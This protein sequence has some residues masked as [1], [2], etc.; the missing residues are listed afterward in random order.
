[1]AFTKPVMRADDAVVITTRVTL[2]GPSD[3][4]GSH[5]G[6]NNFKIAVDLFF[7]KLKA[8]KYS[9][10]LQNG[11]NSSFPS[12]FSTRNIKRRR[13][14]SIYFFPNCSM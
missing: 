1:M 2:G 14:V 3:S 13:T 11:I 5:I 9:C 10:M 6:C 8:S 4:E 12:C 7:S